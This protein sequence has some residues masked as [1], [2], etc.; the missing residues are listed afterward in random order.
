MFLSRRRKL[1]NLEKPTQAHR[2]VSSTEKDHE[3]EPNPEP[4]GPDISHAIKKCQ[5]LCFWLSA[6]DVTDEDVHTHYLEK[7]K[8]GGVKEH[9]TSAQY[10]G[11]EANSED[12]L[13]HSG[14]EAVSEWMLVRNSWYSCENATCEWPPDL[15]GQREVPTHTHPQPCVLSLDRR[16]SFPLS[17]NKNKNFIDVLNQLNICTS[18]IVHMKDSSSFQ[19]QDNTCVNGSSGSDAD[20]AQLGR[21]PPL[22]C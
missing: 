5:Q 21:P 9:A 19:Q 7:W 2:E 14:G 1:E 11:A 13:L 6:L 16:S 3:W 20:G 22:S 10:E 8:N 17:K 4:S 15:T 18:V 12:T